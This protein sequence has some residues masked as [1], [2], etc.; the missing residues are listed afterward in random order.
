MG[1]STWDWILCLDNRHGLRT[2]MVYGLLRSSRQI[3]PQEGSEW[4]NADARKH[5][6]QWP[7]ISDLH[8]AFY[9]DIRL[10]ASFQPQVPLMG[11]KLNLPKF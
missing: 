11:E 2:S 10:E 7:L 9:Q 3:S 1:E 4:A 5:L 6:L 8:M